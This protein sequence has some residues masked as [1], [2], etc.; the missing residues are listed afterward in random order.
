MSKKANRTPKS[1]HPAKVE[2]EQRYNQMVKLLSP[3]MKDH[4]SLLELIVELIKMKEDYSRLESECK[5]QRK[6]LAQSGRLTT[7]GGIIVPR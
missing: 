3:H 1:S 4:N 2:R 5:T 7:P 6:V